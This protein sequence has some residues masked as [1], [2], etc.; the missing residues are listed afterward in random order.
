MPKF[1][2][3]EEEVVGEIEELLKPRN[4]EKYLE[5]LGAFHYFDCHHAGSLLTLP[6]FVIPTLMTVVSRTHLT[7]EEPA[8]QG[9]LHYKA[10][11]FEHDLSEILL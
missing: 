8:S 7:K 1:G 2:G 3:R 9:E 4:F 5:V 11:D 10:Q 6:Q